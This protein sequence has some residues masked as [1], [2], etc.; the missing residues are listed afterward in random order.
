MT[1]NGNPSTEPDGDLQPR[2]A[3]EVY[4]VIDELRE[5]AWYAHSIRLEEEYIATYGRWTDGDPTPKE[6]QLQEAADVRNEI[7]AKHDDLVILPADTYA[8]GFLE[9]KLAALRWAEGWEW[10]ESLDT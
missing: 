8:W 2:D 10:D 1:T 9:G 3:A 5:R 4:A 7:E 6:I